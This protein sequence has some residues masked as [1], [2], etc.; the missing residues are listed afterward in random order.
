MRAAWAV[1]L[2]VGMAL[3]GGLSPVMPIAWAAETR[4]WAYVYADEEG[5]AEYEPDDQSGALA[6]VTRAGEG[7]YTV[8]LAGAAAAEGVPM[9]TAAGDGGTHCQLAGFSVSGADE[10]VRV[11][12]YRGTVPDDSEFSLSFFSRS[13]LDGGD[14]AA[15]GYVFNNRPTL[16]D[17]D[18]PP[19]YSTGGPVEIER[20]SNGYWTVHF[21]GDAFDNDSGNVQVS[22]VGPR[23]ARCGIVEWD[24]DDD[25][26]DAV[27]RCDNLSGVAPQWTLVY[28]HEYSLVGDTGRYFG[29]LQA[30]RPDVD[31]D[32]E[33]AP[34]KDRNRAPDDYA[35]RVT[36]RAEGQYEVKVYGPVK[37]P[38]GLHVS[39][40]GDSTRFCTISDAIVYP[41]VDSAQPSALVTVACY[42]SAGQPDNSWFSLNYYSPP[43]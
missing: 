6:K 11:G 32:V 42:T 30:D 20:A 15:Y 3:T 40:N 4:V 35:H 24:G 25:G 13:T 14:D 43:L 41:V 31:V 1:V 28:A 33:Y 38:L 34:D 7:D 12:C 37:E 23:P 29:Y 18:N 5:L 39:V 10:V 21:D 22:A 27:V 36:R 8:R 19:A 26:A 2:A 9:V 16:A 17:Y